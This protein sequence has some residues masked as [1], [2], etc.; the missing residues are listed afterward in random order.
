MSNLTKVFIVL[1][2][3]LAVLLVAVVVTF[4]ASQE[5]YRE[6]YV[7][8]QTDAQIAGDRARTLQSELSTV[9]AD[10]DALQAAE[11]ERADRLQLNLN[12]A[13]TTLAE[14]RGELAQLQAEIG[15]LK[16]QMTALVSQNSV[17]AS[18]ASQQSGELDKLRTESDRTGVALIE[19]T[20]NANA[21]T[22]QRDTLS[23]QVRDLQEKAAQILE[24]NKKLNQVVQQN[25]L[26]VAD[27]SAPTEMPV[28]V[29]GRITAV[30]QAG[31]ATYVEVNLGRKDGVQPN[32]KFVVFRRS[33]GGMGYV[34]SLVIERVDED[35]SS[36][37]VTLSVEPVVVGYQVASGMDGQ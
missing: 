19:A 35:A 37:R 3:V 18:L 9:M 27:T 13:Q 1:V 6:D 7:T 34:G 23:L 17:L 31:D 14:S 25:N 5:N 22:S 26:S 30:Q 11:S 16:A 10:R 36:G 24:E 32:T 2:T 20:D 12:T 33:D 21:L 29:Y 15:Q 28:P 8:L 4:V